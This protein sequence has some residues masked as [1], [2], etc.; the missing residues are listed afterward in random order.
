M[1]VCLVHDCLL[2]DACPHCNSPISIRDIVLL[3][4]PRCRFDLRQATTPQNKVWEH[5][6]QETLWIWLTGESTLD[7]NNMGWPNHSSPV[8]CNLAEGLAK[9]MLVFLERF[10]P[11]LFAP[12]APLR[13]Q[14]SRI[15]LN[16]LRPAEICWAY[17]S[18]LKWMVDWPEGFREFLH[19]CA[20]Q[21]GSTLEGKLGFFYSP[22]ICKRWNN[23]TFRF[24]RDAFDTFRSD[25]IWFIQGKPKRD[26][27]IEHALAYANLKE[28]AQ[29]LQIPK[30][31][32]HRMGQIGLIQ[33]VA[34]SFDAFF[35]RRDLRAVKS[36]WSESLSVEEAAEW[37]G[38]ASEIVL[39]L[40]KEK[41]L[42]VERNPEQTE[43]VGVFFNR[44]AVAR[45]LERV[46]FRTIN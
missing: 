14:N 6:A 9:A 7:Y 21:P 31:V 3:R 28:A 40:S 12:P 19:H 37:L 10:P 42:K 4:C 36:C 46:N 35:L 22:W 44:N 29:I 45:L 41:A 25:R 39:N 34:H 5:T 13:V 43:R 23:E 11:H 15:A 30:S 1:G 17:I 8:L 24:I 38:V 33:E 20:P 32:V 18:A 16:H 2:A 27:P 26:A